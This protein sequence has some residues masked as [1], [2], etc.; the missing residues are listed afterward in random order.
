MANIHK[1]FNQLEADKIF[2]K[3]NSL[4]RFD[5]LVKTRETKA[6]Y[7]RA[8]LYKVLIDFNY[9]NDRQ[10]VD[11]FLT[12]GKKM[13]RVS[14]LQAVRKIDIYYR[15]F[16]DF[17]QLYDVYFG[18]KIEESKLIKLSQ[19]DKINN[20]NRRVAQSLPNYEKDALEVF[21]DTIPQ[22]RRAEMLEFATLRAQSWAWKTADRCEIIES[23]CSVTESTF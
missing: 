20:L 22:N 1:D 8:L 11:Y 15:D 9:M 10:V 13:N 14:V 17:R 23:C 4:S 5:P 3:Y 16:A 7:F 12:K 18:D 2:N 6:V 21:I 19:R